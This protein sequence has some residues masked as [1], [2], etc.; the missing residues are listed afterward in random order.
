M[1]AENEAR[2]LYRRTINNLHEESE[3]I[4]NNSKSRKVPNKDPVPTKKLNSKKTKG[5]ATNV[6]S[7]ISAASA[8]ASSPSPVRNEL[9]ATPNT[10]G[11]VKPDFIAR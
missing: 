2:E 6:S 9:K 7:A 3:N 5:S 10:D 8:A 4:L 11:A 1:N